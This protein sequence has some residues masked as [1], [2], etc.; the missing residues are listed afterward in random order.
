MRRAL[1]HGFDVPGALEVFTGGRGVIAHTLTSPYAGYYPAIERSIT[2]YPYD[3][4]ATQR[5]LEE[6][7]HV[8]GADGFFTASGERLQV[9]VWNTGGAVFERE[10]RI[11]VDSLRQA[12]VEAIAQ[13]LGPALLNDPQARALIPGLFT[14]G[15]GSDR[16]GD[17]GL[18]TIPR[19]ENRW[20][21]N[22][23]GA[24][25]SPEYDRLL[26]AYNA[27]LDPNDRIQQLT[28]MERLLNE[29]VGAIFHYFTVVVTAHVEA[30]HGPVAR[31]TP[32]APVG[33]QHVHTWE[34]RS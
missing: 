10:N 27:T 21:G 34:W 25:V 2:K 7:G 11:F 8:R 13:T 28:S 30:L 12:G 19:P 1:A 18:A 16:L 20:Q 14:G 17:Y 26:Q 23:R 29:D 15:A 5:L 24:W 4:R 22:N 33:I 31:T 9:E 32:D 3:P 6:A